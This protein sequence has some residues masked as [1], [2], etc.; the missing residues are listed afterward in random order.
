MSKIEAAVCF[1]TVFNKLRGKVAI[2]EPTIIKHDPNMGYPIHHV[3][4]LLKNDHA[5]NE[6]NCKE[7][8][9]TASPEAENRF[10]NDIFYFNTIVFIFNN[11]QYI[12]HCWS[13]PHCHQYMIIHERKTKHSLTR[14]IV[15]K[16]K[17]LSR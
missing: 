3:L 10:Y 11:Y 2:N 1:N 4:S 8:I 12:R 9:F 16:Q 7:D 14:K 15:A 13:F 6:P 17:E 5:I